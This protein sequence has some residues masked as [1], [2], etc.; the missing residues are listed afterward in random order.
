MG[1]ETHAIF[2]GT[3]DVNDGAEFGKPADS[4]KLE[5]PRIGIAE[6]AG[7]DIAAAPPNERGSNKR[8]QRLF[9]GRR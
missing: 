1:R 6:G 2:S 8:D 9:G 3:R 5:C 7:V 4:L